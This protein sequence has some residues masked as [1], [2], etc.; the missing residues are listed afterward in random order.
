[1]RIYIGFVLLFSITT[2]QTLFQILIFV[3]KVNYVN[4][5]SNSFNNQPPHLFSS[6]HFKF[7]AIIK[8]LNN[9]KTVDLGNILN[10]A[11]KHLTKIQHISIY[12]IPLP[13]TVE[14]II[15]AIPKLYK[16]KS[17]SGNYQPINI[18]SSS[19]KILENFFST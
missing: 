3:S 4:Y 10:F 11:L 8:W 6:L 9:R 2:L 1:M 17:D 15:V 18:F 14:E 19:N 16:P 13:Q 12:I 7:Q 5:S